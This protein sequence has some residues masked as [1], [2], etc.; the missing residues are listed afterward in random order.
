MR[1]WAPCSANPWIEAARPGLIFFNNVGF[2]GMC[3]HATIGAAV[4]LAHMGRIAA[5]RHRF[6]TPVGTV[7]ADLRGRNEVTIENVASYRHRSDVTVEVEG[8]RPVKGD[9]AWGGNWFFICNDAPCALTLA[10]VPQL[11]RHAEAIRAALAAA[12]ITGAQGAEIDHIEIL[13]SPVAGDAHSRNFVLCPG[14]AFDR[15]P[16][17]TGLSAKIACLADAGMLA[18]GAEWIQE[19]IV[20][21]R[22]TGRYRR[23]TTGAVIPSITGRAFVTGEATLL[24]DPADPF[25]DGICSRHNR[26]A[27]S[28][29]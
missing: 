6:E 28:A 15:S 17:G 8:M 24:R 4:T 7:T 3:G 9:V 27:A 25:A 12:D 16:C 19:S 13:R 22:F 10:N 21:S 18:E 5:G 23:A 14:N 26:T 20:G 11:T 29:A 2:L 1:W